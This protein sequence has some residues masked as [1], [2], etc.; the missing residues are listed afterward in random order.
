M[1][2]VASL[3]DGRPNN[4]YQSSPLHTLRRELPS[5]PNLSDQ[6]R[7]HVM[8]WLD[9]VME[10]LPD[11]SDIARQTVGR[12]LCVTYA[13]VV[14]AQA[15]AL[16]AKP[17]TVAADKAWNQCMRLQDHLTKRL[18]ELRLGHGAKE[19]NSRGRMV[20]AFS[21]PRDRR[22]SEVEAEAIPGPDTE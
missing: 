2:T 13:G 15:M 11:L 4:Q 17:G 20:Q 18:K 12:S 10:R 6:Q 19:R 5:L 14:Q 21:A 7:R 3:T 8:L 22:P 9:R 16:A 1:R